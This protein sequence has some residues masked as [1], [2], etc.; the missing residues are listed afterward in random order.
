MHW[1]GIMSAG[2]FRSVPSPMLSAL[3]RSGP[4]RLKYISRPADFRTEIGCE[5][6]NQSFEFSSAEIWFAPL[7][8]EEIAK[9]QT[10]P[11]RHRTKHHLAYPQNDWKQARRIRRNAWREPKR[12]YRTDVLF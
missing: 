8:K 5:H 10:R 11:A 2:T 3:P 4:M 1:D 6:G 9:G 7:R 12:P